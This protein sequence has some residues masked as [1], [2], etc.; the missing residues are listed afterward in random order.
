MRRRARELRE[1][2]IALCKVR[3][4][5]LVADFE[6][7]FQTMGLL[8]EMGGLESD[9]VQIE[10]EFFRHIQY[11]R[12]L[13]L[14]IVLRVVVPSGGLPR[15]DALPR[16]HFWCFRFEESPTERNDILL[17]L[18]DRYLEAEV[19]TATAIVL[20]YGRGSE[21]CDVV[22]HGFVLFDSRAPPFIL[23]SQTL[24]PCLARFE[25]SSV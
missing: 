25:F 22:R 20:G 6:E 12:I 14:V 8:V 1:G 9:L 15:R 24:R 21:S 10:A 18:E 4:E 13:V 2:Q 23:L 16:S 3:A 19:W 17:V 11:I 7:L 5:E